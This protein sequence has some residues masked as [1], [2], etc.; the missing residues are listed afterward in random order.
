[1]LN[2][3]GDDHLALPEGDSVDDSGLDLFRH[4]RIRRLDHADL[5]TRLHCHG[6]G[7]HQIM[8]LLLEAVAHLCVILGRLCVLGKTAAL[9][10]GLK[11]GEFSLTCFLEL[12]LAG[13]NIHG[14]FFVIAQVQL[15]HPVEQ[16]YVLH[17]CDLVLLQLFGDGIHICLDFAVLDLHLLH[18]V[19]AFFEESEETLLLFLH[20]KVFE[21]GHEIGDHAAHFAQVFCLDALQSLLGEVR[22]FFLRA[23]AVGHDCLRI[24]DIDLLDECIDH[25][26]FFGAQ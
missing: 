5:G 10:L 9:C 8:K 22:H 1:M 21:L 23:Y 24:G 18:A 11:L 20:I 15:I 25:F 2:A 6:P 3:D 17:Q 13:E 14:K 16:I 12:L 26:D 4:D 19:A 7:E